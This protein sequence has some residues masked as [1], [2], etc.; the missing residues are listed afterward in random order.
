MSMPTA[1]EAQ[2]YF[3]AVALMCRGVGRN[4][5]NIVQDELINM[6]A[7]MTV[8]YERNAWDALIKSCSLGLLRVGL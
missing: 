3:H 6:I 2:L 4:K 7:A 1:L 5:L 8:Q